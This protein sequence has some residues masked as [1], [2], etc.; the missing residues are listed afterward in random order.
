MLS[1]ISQ[2]KIDIIV[3]VNK[4]KKLVITLN[5]CLWKRLLLFFALSSVAIWLN[6]YHFG[7][8]DQV[9]HIP[10]FKVYQDPTLYSSDP[11]LQLKD[12]HFSY[13]WSLFIP[14]Y[15]AGLF[16]QALFLTHFLVTFFTF[17]TFWGLSETMFHNPTANVLLTFALA[18][19]HLGFPGFQII[20]F[21]LLNRTFALP[22]LLWAITLYLQ[23]K[24]IWS[25]LLLGA[26]FNIHLVYTAFVVALIGMDL[27]LNFKKQE[28]KRVIP[29]IITFGLFC[30]PML[31]QKQGVAP[32]IDLTLRPDLAKL[33]SSSLLYT[34]YYPIGPQPYVWASTIQGIAGVVIILLSMRYHPVRETDHTMRSF[35]AAI[36]VVVAVGSLGSW[37]LPVTFIIQFQMI[38]I[39]VFLLYFTYLY[40][41]YLISVTLEFDSIQAWFKVLLVF[42]LVAVAL[43]VVPLML[44]L[45]RHT[46]LRQITAPVTITLVLLICALEISIANAANLFSPGLFID[47]ER[48]DWRDAQEWAREN[49]PKDALFITPPYIFW[50]YES[51]W[52]VFSE[53]GTVVSICESME[54]HYYP[55]FASNFEMRM[56]DLAPGSIEKFNGNYYD[57]MR[58]TQ[59]AFETLDDDDLAKVADKYG[60]DYL[61]LPRGTITNFASVY[62]N[63][64]YAVYKLD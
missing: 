38:R 39:G 23:K 64:S 60:A 58:F 18:F 63:P 53:R 22:F 48:S 57:T 35:L 14:A 45:C 20:E 3:Y 29:A 44:W 6:G 25:A 12:F 52:R 1:S 41:A 27:L 34:V 26:M 54:L 61:V 19:P 56:N 30:L 47:G 33:E 55:P 8:F 2:H 15:R 46:R 50:H 16:T 4:A 37:F 5:Q 9:F 32:G 21:S 17:V 31:F 13:F 7:T 40:L 24:P 11:F 36:G 62:Q 51:D 49:T 59:E 43:P 10:F 28:W 42:S